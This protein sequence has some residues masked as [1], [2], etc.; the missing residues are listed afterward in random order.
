MGRSMNAMKALSVGD[1]LERKINEWYLFHGTNPI[2]ADAICSTDFKVSKAGTNTGTL[3]GKGLY[4][5]DC[6]TKA[7]EYSKPNS[8]GHYA[9]LLCR[10]IGGNVRYTDEETPDKEDLVYSCLEGPYD[11]VLGDREKL[12]GTFKE[13]VLFDSEDVYPEY[14]IHYTRVY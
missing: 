6:I 5:A 12:R 13:Y 1:D 9:V 3:Y 14:I 11:C 4:F 10:I 7:D 8:D 2:A